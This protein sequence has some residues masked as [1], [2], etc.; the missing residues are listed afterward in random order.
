[1]STLTTE[2]AKT[3]YN[4]YGARQESQAF[5]ED[6]AFA[7]LEKHANFGCAEYVFEFGCGT[8]R[9]AQRLFK[10]HLSPSAEYKAVDVSETMV[11]LTQSRLRPWAD[12]SSIDVSEGNPCIPNQAQKF[13]R[14]IS[15]FVLDL[16][17]EDDIDQFVTKAHSALAQNGLLCLAS[18]NHGKSLPTRVISL[19]WKTV[20]RL[21]PAR[22]GGCRPVTLENHL[23]A[24]TWEIQHQETQSR[25]GLSFSV[26]VAKPI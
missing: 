7:A 24:I 3:Y 6:A 12:R 23:P 18:L 2:Q 8:G 20:Y 13:D 9:F 26:V 19:I 17:C 14:I 16:L 1:M 11:A 5:Y 15:T 21:N 4:R 22:V 10:D 25:R